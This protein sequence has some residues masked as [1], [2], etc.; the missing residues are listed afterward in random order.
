MIPRCSLR[1]LWLCRNKFYEKGNWVLDVDKTKNTNNMN[2]NNNKMTPHPPVLSL[3]FLFSGWS[4]SS[5]M[6]TYVQK[7]SAFSFC[8]SR[9]SSNHYFARLLIFTSLMYI[10]VLLRVCCMY[11]CCATHRSRTLFCTLNYACTF[12]LVFSPS[13]IHTVTALVHTYID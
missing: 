7:F 4:A 11:S 6:A 8:L 12:A 13:T 3:P 10:H 1:L 9:L 5:I 2:N